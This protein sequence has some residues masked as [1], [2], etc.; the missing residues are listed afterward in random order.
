MR[1]NFG[2]DL[3]KLEDQDKFRLVCTPGPCLEPDALGSSD[4]TIK[5]ISAST[6]G[7]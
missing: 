7:H 5:E 6:D 3:K 2:W 1:E 4:A